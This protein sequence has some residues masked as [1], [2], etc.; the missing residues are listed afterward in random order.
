MSYYYIIF[1]LIV[2]KFMRLCGFLRIFS[3]VEFLEAIF[4]VD[5]N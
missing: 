4:K 1:A 2:K 5:F 3:L